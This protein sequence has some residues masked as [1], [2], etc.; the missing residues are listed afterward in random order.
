MLDYKVRK[1]TLRVEIN[2][3][4]KYQVPSI[5]SHF[6]PERGRVKRKSKFVLTNRIEENNEKI[7]NEFH[8]AQLCERP[9]LLTSR[10]KVVTVRL[11]YYHIIYCKEH[12]CGSLNSVDPEGNVSLCF[13]NRE[14]H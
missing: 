5:E 13:L 11:H 9:L 14:T 10:N 6:Y 8:Y 2:T 1:N 4:A 7:N 12:F 3:S